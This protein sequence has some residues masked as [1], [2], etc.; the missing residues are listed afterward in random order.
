MHGEQSKLHES[1]RK[2]LFKRCGTEG[3]QKETSKPDL[4]QH[5]QTTENHNMHVCPISILSFYY[6]KHLS[7]N[8]GE[9]VLQFY[10]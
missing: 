8:G 10:R 4:N 6:H 7:V 1:N 5:M 9:A 2:V 3:K